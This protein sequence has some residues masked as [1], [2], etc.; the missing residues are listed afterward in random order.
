MPFTV[1]RMYQSEA[2]LLIK[3][4]LEAKSPSQIWVNDS[5][6]KPVDSQGE[7]IINTELQILSSLD[8]ARDVAMVVGPEKVLGQTG[9]GTNVETAA[10]MI[11]ANLIT[12]VPKGSSVIRIVFQHPNRQM[13]QPILRQVV[14]SYLKMQ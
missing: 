2:K 3:Y 9:V 12:D 7:N 1:P 11:R 14:D 6:I 5:Q 10:A 13:V 8:L 4:L